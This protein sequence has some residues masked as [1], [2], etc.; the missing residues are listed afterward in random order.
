[1]NLFALALNVIN[2]IGGYTPKPPFAEI[3]DDRTLY[4]TTMMSKYYTDDEIND[5]KKNRRSNHTDEALI[6]DFKSFE[7]PHH[8]IPRDDNY[9]RAVER[10]ATMFRP[11]R[12]L[13]PVSFPDLRYY[14]WNLKPNAEAPWNL[15][16]F[17]FTPQFR[18]VDAET[19]TPKQL[20]DQATLMQKVTRTLKWLV[21]GTVKVSDY[22]AYK[23]SSGMTKDVRTSFHNLYSEIFIFNRNLVHRIKDG[24]APFW[25]DGKPVPYYWN[26]LHARAHVVGP[27]D[28]D[29]IRAVFGVTK[30]LL[31]VENMF[32]WPMQSFYLNEETSPLLW[33]REI[34]K[35]GWR[36]LTNEAY[37]FGPRSTFLTLDWSQ[38]DKR[39]LHELIRDVHAIWRSYFDFTIYEPT[40]FYPDA[41][42]NPIRIERL[43]QWMC[44]SITDTPTA[45]PNGELYIWTSNGFASGFQQT[46]LMDSFANLIMILTCLAAMG[47]KIESKHFWI[48]IQGDD[49]LVAFMELMFQTYGPTFLT[50]LEA[51]ALFY[52]NAKVNVKKSEISDNLSGLTVLGYFNKYGMPFRTDEDLLRHMLFPEH[53]QDW[54]RTLSSALGLGL[55][56]C[57]CSNRFHAL[58]EDIIRDLTNKGFS[59]SSTG[60]L[61]QLFRGRLVVTPNDQMPTSLPSRLVL[62]AQANQ[63]H[64]RTFEE[65]QRIWPTQEGVRRKFF[66]LSHL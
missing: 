30:L 7:Q 59:L 51:T 20:N 6:E 61:Y 52:F 41:K 17:T 3:Q 9:R 5:V 63:P 11:S 36:R 27:E 12:T 21:N 32:I 28:P 60:Y 22:L 62:R 46:Q 65:K 54:N 42:T 37:R 58:C 29:K 57:G 10:T 25:K 35:G 38:F 39:L 1:M 40:S 24:L 53:N 14:P 31:M 48:R 56:A 15:N 13:H 2:R 44:S 34:M 16:G 18:D 49:S 50:T 33:G 55:A 64:I 4:L 43:W 19:T 26:T 47:I 23:Q 45:L 66:F 8:P